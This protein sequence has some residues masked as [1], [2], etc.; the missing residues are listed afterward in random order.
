MRIFSQAKIK[1]AAVIK[2][3]KIFQ[4]IVEVSKTATA[5]P[6]QIGIIA[7][8]YIGGL[9]AANHNLFFEAAINSVVIET[10]F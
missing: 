3:V 10:G 7:T 9:I 6:T 4:L 1:I 5:V 8:L 2:V